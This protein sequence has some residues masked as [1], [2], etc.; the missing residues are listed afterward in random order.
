MSRVCPNCRHFRPA[1]TI[2][3]AWQCPACGK[4]YSKGGGAPVDASYGRVG[5]PP[6][7]IRSVARRLP[8]LRLLIV[9]AC[10]G[11]IAVRYDERDI[12]QSSAYADEHRRLGGN[13]VP[14]ILIGE[15]R[16]DGYNEGLLRS[17]LKHWLKS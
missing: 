15:D 4:A 16:I 7:I 1:D 11:G 9:G 17:L 10:L 13:G 14:L 8:V 3:P 5:P 2:A 12:E 6:S